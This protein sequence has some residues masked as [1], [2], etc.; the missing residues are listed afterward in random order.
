[1]MMLFDRLQGGR[2]FLHHSLF[3][4]FPLR[5]GNVLYK[6][7]VA[8]LGIMTMD[9]GIPSHSSGD[10]QHP[11][12][13]L[14]ST[15]FRPLRLPPSGDTQQAGRG[16]CRVN[17]RLAHLHIIIHHIMV[18]FTCMLLD[19]GGTPCLISHIQIPPSPI[20]WHNASSL[21]TV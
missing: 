8:V 7:M 10:A 9:W 20:T 17:P 1:M 5:G 6:H 11:T 2:L 21:R 3:F 4:L 15:A 12:I 18:R 16:V 19:N 13:H 14:P